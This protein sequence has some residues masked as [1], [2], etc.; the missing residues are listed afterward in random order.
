M[1]TLFDSA[2]DGGI[3]M[4]QIVLRFDIDDRVSSELKEEEDG[5]Y[6][7]SRSQ[8]LAFLRLPS[9]FRIHNGTKRSG[10]FG[11][12]TL[13]DERHPQRTIRPRILIT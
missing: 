4:N 7:I 8:F 11:K 3:L 5:C 1:G 13:E 6:S 9:R 12:T 10:F 2:I